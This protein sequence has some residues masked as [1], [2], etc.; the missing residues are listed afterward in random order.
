M[1]GSSNL[2]AALFFIL[3][4]IINGTLYIKTG[5]PI[6]F[7]AQIICFMVVILELLKFKKA[8]DDPDV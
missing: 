3:L 4:T 5:E 1:K 7:V 6:S 2:I 8:Q